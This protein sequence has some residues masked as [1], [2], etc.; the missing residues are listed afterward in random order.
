[1]PTL[2]SDFASLIDEASYS[3]N[4]C[5]NH[6]AGVFIDGSPMTHDSRFALRFQNRRDFV[7]AAVLYDF[8]PFDWP[9]YLTTVCQRIEYMARL[10]RLKSFDLFYPISEYTAWRLASL[11]G[12]DENRIKV[13][14]ASVRRSLYEIRER[15]NG[16]G[17]NPET[18]AYFVTLGGD[19][20]RKNT[21]V[22]VRAVQRLNSFY[23]RRIPLKVIGHYGEHYKSELLRIAGHSEG[24]GFLEFYSYIPDEEVVSLHAGALAAIAPSH[25]E[26][27][28][29]PVVEASVCGCP[30]IASSCAAQMELVDRPEALFPSN[31]ALALSERLVALL[32]NPALRASLIES[33]AHLARRF[34]EEAVGARFWNSIGAAVEGRRTANNFKPISRPCLAFLSPHSPDKSDG[35]IYTPMVVKAGK[36][37]FNSEVFSD[38]ARPLMFEDSFPDA[39]GLS[40]VPLLDKRFDGI[41][42][43][44]GN[45]LAYRQVFDIFERYGGP[46]ILH[47]VRLTQF[48][49]ERLGHP[50]FL[51]FAHSLLGRPVSP[52]ELHFWLL[53]RNPPS[54]CVE[55]VIKHASPLMVHSPIQQKLLKELYGA[56][57]HLLPCCPSVCFK[58]SDLALETKA[59]IRESL[60][61]PPEEFLI[62]SFGPVSRATGMYNCVL[63]LEILRSWEIPARLCFVGDA[64]PNKVELDNLCAVY[65]VAQHVYSGADFASERAYRDFLIASDVAAQIRPY[66]FGHAPIPLLDCISAALPCVANTDA[67]ESCDA[68]SYIKRVPD[69]VSPLQV[70]EQLASIWETEDERQSNAEARKNFLQAHNFQKY[71]ERLL[72]ILGVA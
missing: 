20:K 65:G 55:R 7:G 36:G 71:A 59:K 33:Q 52:E 48:Y 10:A 25:I 1:M 23:E 68:P 37:L 61:I 16:A 14:G 2:P 53:D 12:I 6:C 5:V 19:D 39:A 28:S 43:V 58:D 50:G 54:L 32:H 67:A 41:I 44:L 49:F 45:S 30:V 47:D 31:D 57:A 51:Q 42:S 35:A 60:G 46:C 56:H 8:I 63:A 69:I 13:T 38:S 66:G 9:G 27:F 40:V 22:A 24:A 64:G 72:Q 62:A 34:H 11:A 21:E 17:T 70:A 3:L 15:I 29:L 26:G 4:P 18:P